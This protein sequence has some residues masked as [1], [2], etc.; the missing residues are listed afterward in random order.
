MDE[1]GHVT[2]GCLYVN[3]GQVQLHLATFELAIFASALAD[4]STW[5]QHHPELRHQRARRVAGKL[6]EGRNELETSSRS[7]CTMR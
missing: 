4:Q 5:A 3:I 1:S 2:L 7:R 6:Q